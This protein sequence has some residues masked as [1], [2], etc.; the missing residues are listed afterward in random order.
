MD[1]FVQ[2][3]V[4]PVDVRVFPREFGEWYAANPWV[5]PPEGASTLP[6]GQPLDLPGALHTGGGSLLLRIA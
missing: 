1:I 4:S 2:L 6:A 5:R 3:T